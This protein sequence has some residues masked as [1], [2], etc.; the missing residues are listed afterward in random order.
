MNPL[1]TIVVPIYNVEEYLVKC[2][3]SICQQTYPNLQ[4]VLVNDGS[5]DSSG[6]ICDRYKEKDERIEVIHQANCGLV[7]ARKRGIERARGKYI[8]FVDGDD[9]IIPEMYKTLVGEMEKTGVDFIHTGYFVGTCKK[10]SCPSAL[11]SL[12]GEREKLL[13]EAVFGDNWYISPSIWSKIFKKP[14]IEKCYKSVPDTSSYGEDLLSL[15]RCIF[16]ANTM[17]LMDDAFYCYREREES[18][19]R[20]HEITEA[21]RKA[22]GLYEALLNLFCEYGVQEDFETDLRRILKR[23]LAY[24]ISQCKKDAFQFVLY[25]Y[26]EP[27]RLQGKNIVLYG[28]GAVGRAYYAQISRYPDC[29]ICAWVDR[30]SI[31]PPDFGIEVKEVEIIRK[32]QY[33]CI[34]IALKSKKNADSARELLSSMGVDERR[35]LWTAPY[36]LW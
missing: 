5:T 18:L 35:I 17:L 33:D 28:A 24:W 10:T 4:I 34:L 23:N 3:E 8:G 7:V 1:V 27:Q 2:I 13:H 21:V 29:H 22:V 32:V 15:C 11:I 9:Y 16:E 31:S 25:R 19:S 26:P 14:L 12:A 36:I 6:E 20:T 30:A